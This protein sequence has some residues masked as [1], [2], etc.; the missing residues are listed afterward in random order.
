[1]YYNLARQKRMPKVS[2]KSSPKDTKCLYCGKRCTSKGV[3]E[4]ERHHCKTNPHRK[5]RSFGKLQCHVCGQMY[6]AAGLRTHMAVQHPLEFAKEKRKRPSSKAAMRRRVARAESEEQ[7][8]EVSRSPASPRRSSSHAT[9][10]PHD[11]KHRHNTASEAMAQIQREMQ[12]AA[13]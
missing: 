8:H 6:H 10:S 1:M 3:Y 2:V 11:K 7:R 4:H 9:A 12:R 13:N 5:K